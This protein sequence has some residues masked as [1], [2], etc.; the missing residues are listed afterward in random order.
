MNIPIILV[1]EDYGERQCQ[2][3]MRDE[4]RF[5]YDKQERIDVRSR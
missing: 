3:L 2:L 1:F 4:L 5:E